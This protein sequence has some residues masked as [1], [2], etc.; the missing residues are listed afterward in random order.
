MNMSE[1]QSIQTANKPNIRESLTIDLKRL[2]VKEGMT[3]IVHSSLSSL[4]WV[5]GGPVTVVQALMDVIGENGTIVMPTQTG[6]NSDPENWGNPPVPK[7]WWDTI[8][9]NMPAYHPDYTPT[10]SMGRIVEVF[11]TYPNVKRSNHPTYSFAAW[12]KNSDYILS[13]HSLEEGFGERSPL[14]KIF[15]L[16]GYIL[17][18][19]TGYDSNTSLHLAEHNI[20]NQQRINKGSALF[21]DGVRVWKEYTEINYDSDVFEELGSDFELYHS[22]GSGE[23]GLAKCKLISQRELVDFARIWLKN[24]QE[25]VK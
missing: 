8:R 12:G 14:G 5:C 21:E 13:E 19:G 23:V 6:D 16:D 9:E 7:E 24:R 2:G 25:I 11:R 20:P 10:R 1:L 22:I 3:I 18:I 17:L 4:G 15:E